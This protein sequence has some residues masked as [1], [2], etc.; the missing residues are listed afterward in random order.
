MTTGTISAERYVD[1]LV[2]FGLPEIDK[3]DHDEKKL[4]TSNQMG[5]T[6]QT[7]HVLMNLLSI[8]WLSNQ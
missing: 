2:K 4:H 7:V 5:A 6:S 3:N 8:S 1:L